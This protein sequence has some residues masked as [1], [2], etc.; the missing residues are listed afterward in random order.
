MEF[1]TILA[2]AL[3]NCGEHVEDPFSLYCALCDCVGNDYA[4]SSQMELFHHFN[5]TYRLVAEMKKNPEPK[6]I[7]L[8]LEKCKEQEDAPVKQCLQWIHSLFVYFYRASNVPEEQKE[9]VLK[10]IEQDF[11]EPEQEGLILPKPKKARK[12]VP[13]KAHNTVKKV[14]LASNI[15]A[16]MTVHPGPVGIAQPPLKVVHALIPNI[17]D[18]AWVYV[19]ENS[20]I[21]HVSADCPHIRPTL[22]LTLYKGTYERARYND[23]V[24]I[25]NITKHTWGN[26]YIS[27]KHCPPIC[28]KCGEFTPIL[29]CHNPKREYKQL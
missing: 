15:T 18:K 27:K 28:P 21:I 2:N 8:L 25:N 14:T 22:K 4:L 13:R 1:R 5:K 23:F 9:Q 26:Y 16:P 29:S 12:E 19:A 11:F 17:P 7:G 24:R 6:M 10:S 20:P 3:K